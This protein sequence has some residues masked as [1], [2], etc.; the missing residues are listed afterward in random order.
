MTK[1]VTNVVPNELLLYER[2]RHKLTQEEVAEKLGL[3]GD[4]PKQVGRWERGLVRPSD[5]SLR[6]LE[7]FYSRTAR[8]L[9][10]PGPGDPPI[11]F[12]IMPE[13]PPNPTFTGRDDI[14]QKL[15]ALLISL[16]HK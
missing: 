14:L 2:I 16:E 8:R 13:H 10:Y 3:G 11:P 15:K 9:G 1:R 4:G 6:M 7:K 12:L 5:Y